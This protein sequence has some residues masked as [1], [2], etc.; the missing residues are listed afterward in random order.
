MSG[1]TA[2]TDEV[3]AWDNTIQQQGSNRGAVEV[4]ILASDEF[5]ADANKDPSTFITHVYQDVLKRT[6][7]QSEINF[8]L[9]VYDSH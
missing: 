2:R 9:S 8:W 5:F 6:P 4:S 3:V 1:R 7:S